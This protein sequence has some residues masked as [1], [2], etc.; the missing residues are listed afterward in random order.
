[1]FPNFMNENMMNNNNNIDNESYYEILGISKD[2][3][4]DEIKKAFRSLAMK[5]HPD[6][7]I[8]NSE[9]MTEKFKEIQ[10]AHSILSDKHKKNI[11]DRFGK[12]AVNDM[13]TDNNNPSHHDPF[14]IISQ[15]MGGQGMNGKKQRGKT[16][17]IPIVV[18]TNIKLCDLFT[19]T[20]IT[21]NYTKEVL[22]DSKNNIEDPTGISPC[23]HCHCN[24]FVVRNKMVAPNTIQ[25]IREPCQECKGQKFKLFDGFELIEKT[26][27]KKVNIPKGIQHLDMIELKGEGNFNPYDSESCY[28]DLCIRINIENDTPFERRGDNL[29]YVQNI[30]VFDSLT[31]VDF[32]LE[33]L[34]KTKINVSVKD[35]IEPDSIRKI[36]QQGLPNKDNNTIGD[37]FIMFNVRYPKILNYDEQL[38]VNKIQGK[39]LTNIEIVHLQSLLL[40]DSSIVSNDEQSMLGS[41]GDLEN[42]KINDVETIDNCLLSV[43]EIIK[44]EIPTKQYDLFI[45]KLLQSCLNNNDGNNNN[46]VIDNTKNNSIKNNFKLSELNQKK[47]DLTYEEACTIE[48][49]NNMSNDLDD[50]SDEENNNNNNNMPHLEETEGV[51]CNHQ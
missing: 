35:I 48:D 23:L 2:A 8:N 26:V 14:D 24:G 17:V 1:M 12:G 20:Q 33:L 37:L 31:G 11:Y 46:H 49:I 25:Q 28:G 16:Q 44:K 45:K 9:E 6:K 15:M 32:E 18:D 29:I 34:N 4:G 13:D 5:Y 19:D 3:T 50:N 38:M 10:E 39:H 43:M 27:E 22:Y 40:N 42:M 41:N 36:S 51:Q 7:N 21:V 30:G 47:Y